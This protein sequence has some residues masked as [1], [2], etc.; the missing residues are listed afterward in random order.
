[1]RFLPDM[2]VEVA[3]KLVLQIRLAASIYESQHSMRVQTSEAP[4][5]SIAQRPLIC[6]GAY[7]RICQVYAQADAAMAEVAETSKEAC[8][9]MG[10]VCMWDRFKM[11]VG[12]QA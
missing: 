11:Q 10:M 5:F 2:H 12:R 3:G 6:C 8:I 9:E 7:N 1:M 4:Q